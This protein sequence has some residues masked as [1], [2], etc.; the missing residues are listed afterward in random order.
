MKRIQRKL[1]SQRGETLVEVMASILVAV[2]SVGLL[3]NGIAVSASINRQGKTMDQYFY[4]TLTAAENRQVPVTE[5]IAAHPSIHIA[6][7]AK[8]VDIPVQVYGNQGM[9]AYALTPAGG[10]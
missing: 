1:H 9:Y 3:L 8:T 2:L 4:E 6:E 5:G 7:G 10:G